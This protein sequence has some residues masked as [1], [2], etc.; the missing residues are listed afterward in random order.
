MKFIPID[1]ALIFYNETLHPNG[2]FELFFYKVLQDTLEN[3]KKYLEC[4]TTGN[5]YTDWKNWSLSEK[6][7][8]I[9]WP[10]ISNRLATK[11][12]MLK[13][14]LYEAG[15]ID[16]MGECRYLLDEYFYTNTYVSHA[17]FLKNV[18]CEFNGDENEI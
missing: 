5:F 18:Y 3:R 16:E 9:W 11:D 6:K 17:D 15:K 14:F 8:H 2:K 4:K 7:S 12:D 1:K 13:M 10:W